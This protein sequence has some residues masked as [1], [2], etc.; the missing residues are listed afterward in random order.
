MCVCMCVYT[1]LREREDRCRKRESRFDDL[2]LGRLQDRLTERDELIKQLVV[3]PHAHTHTHT[4]VHTHARTHAHTYTCT[5]KRTH[6]HALTHKTHTFKRGIHITSGRVDDAD[7]HV[8][9]YNII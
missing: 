9:S 2:Q 6:T 7:E 3:R 8:S 4:H 1:R 5:H